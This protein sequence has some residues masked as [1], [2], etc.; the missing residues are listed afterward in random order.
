MRTVKSKACFSSQKSTLYFFTLTA[1]AAQNDIRQVFAGFRP[2]FLNDVRIDVICGA[3]LTMAKHFRNG[4]NI[5]TIGNQNRC[6]SMA[7]CVG[8]DMW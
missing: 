7:E 5:D 8:V 1:L 6:R 2:L 3:D 4:Y